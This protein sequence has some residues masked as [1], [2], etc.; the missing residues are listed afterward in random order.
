MKMKHLSL[1]GFLSL[2][3]FA[4]SYGQGN[5]DI[6]TR[7]ISTTL[8]AIENLYVDTVNKNKLAEDAIIALLAKLDPH[9][10]YMTPEEVKEMNEPLQG[11]FDGIGVQFNML[12][13][14]LYIIQVISG[15]PS[16]KVGIMAGDRII[17]VNDTLIAGVGMKNTDIMSRLRGPKGTSVTVKIKRGNNPSLLPFKI[18]RDKIPIYSLDASYMINNETGYIKLNR[19]AATTYDEFMAAVKELQTKGMKDLILDLQGNGGGYMTAAIDISNEFLKQGNLIVYTQGAHQRREDARASYK[20]SIEK[21]NVVVLVDESSASASE[22]V[23]GAL[24]DWDRAVVV[25]RR[26]FG[27][28]LVQRPV[29][30]P[31]GSMLRL[32]TARYYTPTGRSIQKPY[33]KGDADS[34]NREV[35]TRY[36]KGELTSAD[37]IHF[38]DSLKYSTLVYHRTVYGGGGIMPDYFVPLDTTRFTD[39]HRSLIASG[40]FNKYVMNTIDR[41][42]KTYNKQYPN[43]NLFKNNFVVSEQMINDLVKL[44]KEEKEKDSKQ[45]IKSTLKVLDRKDDIVIVREEEEEPF[46]FTEL[47]LTQLEKSKP[48]IKLQIK[49]MIARDLWNMNEYFQII[50]NDNDALKKAVQIIGNESEYNKLLGRN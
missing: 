8:A 14:T 9:S 7:K 28:G 33:E 38:P 12:T 23:T 37:S 6:A 16:E 36:N 21:G 29:P 50:N 49:A 15:G 1:I 3:L 44:Y 46:D 40:T 35:I 41:N 47:D 39:L 11:N 22:I 10:N 34:Y 20:G 42:R 45:K 26:S 19:F 18:I 48:L 4:C 43:F 24:Q 17:L 31:D 13:D 32:T 25:G 2:C 27:K 30:L 5:L